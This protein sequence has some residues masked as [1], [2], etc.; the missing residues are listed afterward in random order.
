MSRATR[1]ARNNCRRSIVQ[2]MSSQQVDS[3]GICL[4]Y[5]NVLP[6]SY[7]VLSRL[8]VMD[9]LDQL[10]HI[11]VPPLERTSLE[12]KPLTRGTVVR[13]CVKC[14][15]RR[16]AEDIWHQHVHKPGVLCRPDVEELHSW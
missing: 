16:S 12:R 6:A 8:V 2:C 11:G 4:T 1:D 3:Y 10:L 15:C 7:A 9:A 14:T 5:H 13:T